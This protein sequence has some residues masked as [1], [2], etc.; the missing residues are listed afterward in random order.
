MTVEQVQQLSELAEGNTPVGL[1]S[2]RL[3][4]REDAIRSK[5]QTEGISLSPPN[6]IMS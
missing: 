4:R 2:V 5:A 3:G 1:M 6:R